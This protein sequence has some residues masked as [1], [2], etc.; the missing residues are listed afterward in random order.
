MVCGKLWSVPVPLL[1]PPAVGFSTT[2]HA[3]AVICPVKWKTGGVN[4]VK[5]AAARINIE[6]AGR[7]ATEV[8]SHSGLWL[9]Y[10]LHSFTKC[11]ICLIPGSWASGR[12]AP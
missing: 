9:E 10:G 3:L 1:V 11:P 12:T 2:T 6:A 5:L 4:V 7:A 8:C